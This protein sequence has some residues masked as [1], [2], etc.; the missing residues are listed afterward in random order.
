MVSI[1]QHI[2]LSFCQPFCRKVLKR[3]MQTSLASL[4]LLSMDMGE[5]TAM[6][7]DQPQ[8]STSGTSEEDN[9]DGKKP[10]KSNISWRVSMFFLECL[11]HIK[12]PF[13]N[14]LPF[15]GGSRISHRGGRAPI[16]GV[17]TSDAGTFW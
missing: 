15:S 14:P 1:Q 17:W 9:D 10:K 7:V 13:S 12:N 4:S 6:E 2:I 16:R 5:E 8:A 3:H 11:L